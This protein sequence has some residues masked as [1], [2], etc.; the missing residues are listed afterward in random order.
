MDF[1]HAHYAEKL[2]LERIAQAANIGGRECQRCFRRCIQIS[3]VQYLIRYR[4]MQSAALLAGGRGLG[5]AEISTRCGFDS[6]S[7]FSKT[8]RRYFG[9]TPKEYRNAGR[10]RKSKSG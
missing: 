10:A 2:E 1:I 9:C 6:P 3:P 7:N 4:L 5:I 8:F